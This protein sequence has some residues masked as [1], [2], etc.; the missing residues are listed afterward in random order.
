[1]GKKI[2]HKPQKVPRYGLVADA[3][4]KQLVPTRTGVIHNP[5]Y[6]PERIILK[7]IQ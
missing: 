1:M 2:G 4:K 3:I 7:P 5:K 6:S